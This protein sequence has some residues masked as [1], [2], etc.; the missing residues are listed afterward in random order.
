[1][2][3]NYHANMENYCPHCGAKMVEYKQRLTPGLVSCLSKAI[4]FVHAN[5][6]NE[7]HLQRDLN[8]TKTEFANFQKLRYFALV[9]QVEGKDGSWLI[10]SRGG[11]FLRNE[12]GIPEFVKTYR[13]KVQS[14]SNTVLFY[15][16]FRNK[17]PYFDSE[18][19]YMSR[20]PDP[21]QSLD[22]PV[23]SNTKKSPDLHDP[24]NILRLCQ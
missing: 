10:T 4:E 21:Q 7:F 6:R 16:D 24:K 5:N 12:K 19:E 23:I 9:A 18:F 13:N 15:R 8:L 2:K 3:C 11:E 14:K 17:V 20:F 1:M 22:I